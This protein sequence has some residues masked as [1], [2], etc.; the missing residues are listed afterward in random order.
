MSAKGKIIDAFAEWDDPHAFR[1]FLVREEPDDESE[2]ED[3]QPMEAV[4]GLDSWDDPIEAR[5]Y[6]AAFVACWK[7]LAGRP[8]VDRVLGFEKEAA[9]KR[10]AKAV[11]AELK[12]IEKGEPG[13]T[14]E[15]VSLTAQMLRKKGRRA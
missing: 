6:K 13:P 3:P 15:A 5:L 8:A 4:F 14:D 7:D 1:V 12:R 2:L 9:A 10:V 11:K